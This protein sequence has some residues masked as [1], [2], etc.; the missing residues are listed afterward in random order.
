[1]NKFRVNLHPAFFDPETLWDGADNKK[2]SNGK[3]NPEYKKQSVPNEIKEAEEI[4]KAK[5]NEDL[6]KLETAM[7]IWDSTEID[8]NDID[9]IKNFDYGTL[10]DIKEF[11]EFKFKDWVEKTDEKWK[12]IE[13]NWKKIYSSDSASEGA[14]S[15]GKGWTGSESYFFIGQPEGYN[16]FLGITQQR[17]PAIPWQPSPIFRYR[18]D[19]DK[20]E[21]MDIPNN[22]PHNRNFIVEKDK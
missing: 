11:N 17:H 3:N 5:D 18:D 20:G 19:V 12:Y 10:F 6:R 7:W 22:I 14:I 16:V 4:S 8:P 21:N 1:M 13:I 15:Y 9:T 2:N